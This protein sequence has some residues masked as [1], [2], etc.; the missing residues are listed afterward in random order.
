[1]KKT[2][3]Q[4]IRIPFNRFT[5]VAALLLLASLVFWIVATT[6]G[7][8][9]DVEESA[10]TDYIFKDGADTPVDWQS[11][12]TAWAAEAGFLKRYDLTDMERWEIASVITAEANGEPFAGKVAAAQCILQMCEDDQIRPSEAL[13]KYRYSHDRPEPS[14]ESFEAVQA[15]FDFGYVAT[16]EPIKY[17]YAPANGASN[18]HESQTYVMTINSHRFF[19]ESK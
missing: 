7:S 11:L 13:V 12:T 3:P 14:A 15:V 16:H 1:M 9:V 19:K 17:F 4:K 10:E 18:W 5:I 2:K 6:S 8:S